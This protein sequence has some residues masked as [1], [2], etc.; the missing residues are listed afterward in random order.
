MK[1]QMKEQLKTGWK[2]LLKYL[3]ELSV[4][5]AGIAITLIA[6]DRISNSNEKKDLRRYLSAVKIELEE[7]LEIV[8][9]KREFYQKSAQF[10]NYLRA[11]KIDEIDVDSLRK[12]NDLT[13]FIFFLTYKSSSF[14]MLKVSGVM[15][16]IKDKALLNAIIDCYTMLEETKYDS[17]MYMNKKTDEV[18]KAIL[19]NDG[20]PND[21]R[22]PRYKRLYTFYSIDFDLETIFKDCSQQIQKALD[23]LNNP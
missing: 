20:P 8:K 6:S 11:R 10:G 4:V 2:S 5:V 15:R 21:I 3:R 1:K 13:A 7:N 22:D 19:E 12:Y 23:L 16:L 9:E 17:D 18:F 14:E